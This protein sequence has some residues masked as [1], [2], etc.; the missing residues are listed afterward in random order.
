MSEELNQAAKDLSLDEKKDDVTILESKEEFNVK[1]P[2]N[3]KW[4]LWY[5]KPAVDQSESWSD[6]LKPVVTFDTVEEFWGIYNSIPKV[7]DLPIKSDYHLFRE[8]IKPEWE[9]SANSNGG[10]WTFQFRSKFMEA[11]NI[12]I[13]QIWTRALLSVI[14]ETIEDDENEVNGVVVNVRK[15]TYKVCL[16][17]KSCKEQP[18]KSIGERFKKVLMLKADSLIEFTSHKESTNSHSRPK[19]II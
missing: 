1:H 4:T 11:N 9:D 3:S 15:G 16:W 7:S 8:Q 12:D 14:G 10:K 19:F 18:L 17:T 2:L 6:L 13:N 5:T